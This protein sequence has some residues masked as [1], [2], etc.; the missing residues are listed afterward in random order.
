MLTYH[1]F[2]VKLPYY[3]K[4]INGE[5]DV[6]KAKDEFDDLMDK[7]SKKRTSLEQIEFQE[8]MGKI[9]VLGELLIRKRE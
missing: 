3:E 1:H 4:E 5:L 2:D 9:E 7:L 6:K 8:I